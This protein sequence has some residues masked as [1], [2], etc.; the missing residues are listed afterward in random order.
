MTKNHDP[1]LEMYIFETMH[2]LEQLEDSILRSE[3]NNNFNDEMD[4]IFRIMH[5]LKGNSAM[6]MFNSIAALSHSL[7]DMFDSLRKNK[8]SNINFSKITDLVLSGMDFIKEEIS[9]IENDQEADG[10]ADELINK[11]RDSLEGNSEDKPK[12]ENKVVSYGAVIF[13]QEGCLME[14]IRAFALLRNLEENVSVSEFIPKDISENNESSEIIK[15]QGF[16][17]WFKTDKSYEEIKGIFDKTAFVDQINLEQVSQETEESSGEKPEKKEVIKKSITPRTNV[18]SVKVENLD[19]L[20]DLVGELVVSES[21][22]SKNPDLEGLKLDNFN[23]AARQLRKIINDLQDTVMSA[24]MVPISGTFKKMNRII[25]D[26]NKNL[27]KDVELDLVGEDTEVD[28]NIIEHLS[29]PLM[30]LIRNSMDHGIESP[31]ERKA[32]NKPA[33]GKITL[34]AKNDGG[35]VWICIKDDGKGLDRDKIYNKAIKA[36]ITSKPIG[37][38]TD[39]DIF[40]FILMPGFSTKEEVSEYSGR[41]V[42]MD[43][44][45]KNIESIRGTMYIDSK[46]NMGTTISVKIPLTLAIIDGMIIKV[47]ASSYTI[48]TI[49]IKESFKAKE[50]DLI[51]DPDG[52]EMIMVRG[53]C[54]KIIRIHK[55]YKAETAVTNLPDGIMIMVEDGRKGSYCL[56]ADALI[57]QQQ[58]VIKTLPNYIKKV[59]GLAGCTLLGDGNISLIIDISAIA[60]L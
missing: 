15:S 26:M 24:R 30:H 23:K 12:E 1:I 17:V 28:K 47:G 3:K 51:T 13:F 55:A 7:E 54:H 31:D 2:L 48:P 36:G 20:M 8:S 56:F 58:V 49:S 46:K 27:G 19:M 59:K 6:M 33:K 22:V 60:N 10:N 42:G 40:S 50:K 35:D 37:E 11:I 29:D 38:L 9:K 41:G 5:T 53:E 52:N 25:R 18:L 4:E 14:N 21:M 32:L 57:G 16:K 39:K 43:V 45:A 44:V 34:E